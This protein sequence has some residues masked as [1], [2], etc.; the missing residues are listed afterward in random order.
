M[1]SDTAATRLAEEVLRRYA[2]PA[3]VNH[4]VRAWLF[5]AALGDATGVSYDPELLKVAALLHD[6]GLEA[7]F[8][9]ARVPF[10]VAGGQLAWVFGAGAGWPADRRDRLA[11][12]VERHMWDS[13][14]PADDPEGHLLERSTALDI[15]GRRPEDW[16]DDVRAS[17]L[18]A[19]PRL[20]LAARFGACF[21]DQATRKPASSAA[22]AVRGGLRDRLSSWAAG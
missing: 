17:V 15:S 9:A 7:P 10:E 19:W 12:I 5:A 1:E 11:E 13:V 3:L 20:D 4:A 22:A 18:A 2:A 8:D 16:P 21:T 14:D 6:L